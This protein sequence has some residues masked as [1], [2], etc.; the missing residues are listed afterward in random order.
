MQDTEWHPP[1]QHFSFGLTISYP[2][3]GIIFARIDL[4]RITKTEEII[5]DR[6]GEVGIH[7]N[8]VFAE[9]IHEITIVFELVC[10]ACH[11]T[12]SKKFVTAFMWFFPESIINKPKTGAKE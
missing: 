12:Q 6:A 1:D 9:H 3:I 10:L 4:G 11:R 2:V 5:Q 8:I 7:D